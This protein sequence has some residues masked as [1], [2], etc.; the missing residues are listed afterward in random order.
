[1]SKEEPREKLSELPASED[2]FWEHSDVNKI[3]MTKRGL[4]KC[5]HYFIHRTAREV[6]C[7]KCHIGFV[8]GVDWYIENKHIYYNGK[9][10]I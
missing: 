6:E 2:K 9:F 7:K 1:M 10:V 3:D 4:E 5:D 8:L